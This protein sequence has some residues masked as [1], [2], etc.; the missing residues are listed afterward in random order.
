MGLEP[1]WLVS[2]EYWYHA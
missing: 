2:E 1:T